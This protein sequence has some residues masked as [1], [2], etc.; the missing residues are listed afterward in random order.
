[1]LHI[2]LHTH[3]GDPI[4]LPTGST[5]IGWDVVLSI[6]FVKLYDG[7][8]IQPSQGLLAG[9][10]TLGDSPEGSIRSSNQVKK[11][12][13]PTTSQLPT[14]PH[15][16]PQVL[17]RTTNSVEIEETLE[18]MR[19]TRIEITVLIEIKI[20]ISKLSTKIISSLFPPELKKNLAKYKA[21]GKSADRK[22]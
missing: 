15:P 2:L 17:L 14:P 19:E 8:P 16:N 3:L 4:T 21:S 9:C 6:T 22:F 20:M 1:M 5:P 7:P 18:L 11:T 13:T 10:H 12:T